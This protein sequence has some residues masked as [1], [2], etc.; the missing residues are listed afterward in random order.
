MVTF[1]ARGWHSVVGAGGRSGLEPGAWRLAV[2]WGKSPALGA[3]NH[4]WSRRLQALVY[5][6][7]TR[8]HT[9]WP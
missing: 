2:R 1:G 9:Q 8:G 4:D 6:G 3:S 7:Q 5:F